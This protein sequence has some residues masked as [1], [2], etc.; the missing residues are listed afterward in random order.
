MYLLNYANYEEMLPTASEILDNVQ[1]AKYIDSSYVICLDTRDSHHV[2][3]RSVFIETRLV[4][5]VTVSA[6]SYDFFSISF[7]S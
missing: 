2:S 5:P 4:A 6:A 1:F 3:S 7:A